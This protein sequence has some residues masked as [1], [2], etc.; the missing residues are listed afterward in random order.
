[1]SNISANSTKISGNRGEDYAVKLLKQNGY[2]IIERNFRCKLGEIDI[3]ALDGDTLVFAEVKTRWSTKHGLP[4]EAVNNRKLNHIKRTGEY[5][6]AT[7]DNL[8]KK[9]R[10]DIISLIVSGNAVVSEKIIKCL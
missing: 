8:P 4:E 1:M 7:N 5:Y 2:K 3:I 6:C 9:L 10:I